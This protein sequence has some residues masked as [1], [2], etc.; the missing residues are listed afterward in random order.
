MSTSKIYPKS[1]TLLLPVLNM[2]NDGQTQREIAKVL[3]VSKQRLSYHIN[4]AIKSGYVTEVCRDTFKAYELTQPG[5]NF[6]AM[7]QNNKV[8]QQS[9]SICRAENVRFK[10]PVYKMPSKPVDWHKAEMHNWNQYTT[11]VGSVKIKFNVGDTPTIEFLP[12]TVDGNDPLKLYFKLYSDCDEVAKHLEQT[13]DM[14]IGRLELSSKAEWI[15]YNPLAKAITNTIG[16]VTVNGIGKINASLPN[17]YGEF[18]FYDPMA[19]A[20]FLE[21]PRRLVSLEQDFNGMKHDIKEVLDLIKQRGG[22]S[23]DKGGDLVGGYT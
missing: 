4:K 22:Y 21:M 20:E 8:G 7:Y 5:K 1:L 16:R 11:D 23:E 6:L 12:G 15:V 14:Q 2:I 19:A 18:E 9:R 10:A 13:L 17:R 3:P